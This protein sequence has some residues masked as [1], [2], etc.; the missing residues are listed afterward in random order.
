MGR[1]VKLDDSCV[2]DIKSNT[3]SG[4]SKEVINEN[5]VIEHHGNSDKLKGFFIVKNIKQINPV[6]LFICDITYVGSCSVKV[7]I[8]Y[9]E[10]IESVG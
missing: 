3:A 6:G 7:D 9:E 8:T 2:I 1:I 5:D 4:F 10:I